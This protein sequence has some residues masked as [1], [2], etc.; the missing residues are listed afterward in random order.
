[1]IF[2]LYKCCHFCIYYY[3]TIIQVNLL[4]YYFCHG[5]QCKMFVW[6]DF[7]PF[8]SVIALTFV[9]VTGLCSRA[10]GN[11][12]YAIS[13]LLLIVR[14]R[15]TKK[16]HHNN[17]RPGC[18]LAVQFCCTPSHEPYHPF[19]HEQILLISPPLA[20]HLY[21]LTLRLVP[22]CVMFL[23]LVKNIRSNERPFLS[24]NGEIPSHKIE[25]C[26]GGHVKKVMA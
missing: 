7:D 20:N 15:R 2:F 9:S 18:R 21:F 19:L 16:N 12:L 11:F 10:L 6:E 17:R 8:T 5:P 22:F 13:F 26:R 4:K 14:R 25:K 1:M 3:S 23:H 24:D